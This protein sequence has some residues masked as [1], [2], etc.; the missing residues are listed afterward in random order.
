MAPFPIIL[1]ILITLPYIPS[2]TPQISTSDDNI[3]SLAFAFGWLN[4]N[5]TFVAGD[6]ATIQVIVLG[7]YDH[8]KTNHTFNPNVT[9]DFKMGNSSLVSGVTCNFGG[10][11]STWTITFVPIMVGLLNVLI[12]DDNFRVFD[13]SLHF[14]V[15]PG[16]LYPSAG[17]VS[18]K[19]QTNEFVAGA[20]ATVLILPKD[21]FG[22][23]VTASSEGTNV[24]TF[25]LSASFMNGSIASLYNVTNKGWNEYG[26]VQIEF[27]PITA[28]SLFLNVEAANQ[29]LIGSPVMFKVIPGVLDV[30]SCVPQ[31]KAATKFFQ[32][33]STMETHIHQRDKYGNLVSGLYSFD[34]EIIEKGTNLSIPVADLRFSEVVPGIQ[35]CSFILAEPGNFTLL[36]TDREQINLISQVPYDFTVYVGYCSGSD[37]IINGSGLNDS[38]A[39][40]VSKI[41]VFLRD[42]YQYPSPI[43]LE[44]LRFQILQENET[45]HVWSSIY[46]KDFVN[47]SSVPGEKSLDTFSKTDYALSVYSNTNSSRNLTVKASEFEIIYKPEKSG[48]YHINLFCGNVHLNSGHPIKK[49]VHAGE[50]NTSISGVVKYASS[51]PMLINNEIVVKL[52][53]SFSNPVVS[54]QS[55][56]KLEVSSTNKSEPSI[57]EFVN[58]NDGSYTVLYM[59]KD[60][61]NYEICVAFNGMHFLPCPFGVRVYSIDYF[62]KAKNDLVSVWEDESIAFS[63]LENDYFGGNNASIAQYTKP[64]HGS[65]LQY[66][67]LFRYTPYK[68]FNGNDSF[69]YEISDGNGNHASAFVNISVLSIPPQFA[70]VPSLLQ[71]TED[72][73]SPTFGGFPGLKIIYSDS[74]ENISVRLGARFGTVYLSPMVMQFWQPMWAEL[75]VSKGGEKAKELILEGRLEVLNYA[76]QFIQYFG[77]ENFYGEDVMQ[78]STA[79]RNGMNH[80]EVPILVEPINDPPSI[81]VPEFIIFEGKRKSEEVLIFNRER[82]KFNFSVWDADLIFPGNE[83][84]VLVMFSVEVSSGSISTNLPAEL[85]VTTELKLISSYQW[86]PLQ[87]FVT[88]SKHFKVKAKGIRFRGT[89]HECNSVMQQLSYHGGEHD[90]V[91]KITVND[92]GKYGCFPDCSEMMSK[93]L[94]AEAI[95]KLRRGRLMNSVVAHSLASAIVFEFIALFSLGMVLM[96]FTCKCA[97]VLICERKGRQNDEVQNVELSDVQH[98]SDETIDSFLQNLNF[99]WGRKFRNATLSKGSSSDQHKDTPA[100]LS[101]IAAEDGQNNLENNTT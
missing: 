63:T 21:A 48:I 34:I 26:Y 44:R 39:G 90:D 80:I 3:P 94:F 14:H 93:P 46:P 45:Q 38:V 74:V 57:S 13:S 65:L 61:G 11:V 54:K 85:I 18:W 84:Q 69:L 53:D 19:G 16:R 9:V 60:I 56:L 97:L 66:G 79:N 95:I 15:N 83:T 22:N 36:I 67:H 35:L 42:A 98:A 30:P 100:G 58:N 77:D 92:M 68:G 89:V 25:N 62:P 10:D 73:I 40:E 5:D 47:G 29:T 37:S 41:S 17:V 76:L 12:V 24:S 8:R 99:S 7:N 43:E 101:S 49:V 64:G 71:A 52:M 50:V 78:V 91:L 1:I 82:D 4:D 70:S 81:Y 86:Q 75:S 31:W 87:T 27:V 51:V 72:M 33:F 6:V 96:L 28:G 59:P 2:I 20:L 23:N 88:I 55:K 32:L